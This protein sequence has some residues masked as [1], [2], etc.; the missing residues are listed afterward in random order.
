MAITGKSGVSSGVEIKATVIGEDLMTAI[1]TASAQSVLGI[2]AVGLPIFGAATTAAAQ[3]ALG[4][5]A[6]GMQIFAAATTA[7]VSSIVG[8][9]FTGSAADIVFAPGT[10]VH[11]SATN[12]QTAINQLDGAVDRVSAASIG[13]TAVGKAVFTAATTAAALDTL[14]GT[15]GSGAIV[16]A[17]SPSL[18]TPDIG[19]PSAGTLTNCAGLPVSTGISGLGANV[20]TFLATPSSANLLSA[21]T[22]DTGSGN[23][24]FATSPSIAT[25]V[26]T[27][28][29]ILLS[30][31]AK[32]ISYSVANTDSFKI[33]TNEGS[34]GSITF[35]L[36]AV[37]LGYDFEFIA[38]TAQ[39]IVI[40]AP[41]STTIRNGG[42]VS[43]SA[44][45][46]TSDGTKGAVIRV[47]AI[48]TT[49]YYVVHLTGSWTVT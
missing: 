17:T 27:S 13:G 49:E 25:P 14:G 44:G 37:S 19:T 18:T 7:A 15:T 40:T 35:T 16:L 6:V 5:G 45:S 33:L 23:L 36:P 10:L 21:V 26:V 46:F 34:S 9:G 39:P 28:P 1:T 29:R 31:T 41:A 4:G 20:A 42:S 2:S 38:V 32:T 47:T 22:G 24:V 48:T 8:A 11:V 3:S 43:S 12:V 30:V